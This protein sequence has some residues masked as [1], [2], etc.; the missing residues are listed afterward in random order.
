MEQAARNDAHTERRERLAAR[1]TG[2]RAGNRADLDHIV[3]ELTPL[4][5]HVVRAQGLDP[6]AAEDVVQTTWL[7]LLNH[8]DA[9]RSPSALTAWLV[10]VARREASRV[11]R[12]GRREQLYGFDALESLSHETQEIEDPLLDHRQRAALWRALDDLPPRCRELLRVIARA[13]RPDYDE[14][15]VALGMPRGSIGPTRGRCLAKL[16][17]NLSTSPDWSWP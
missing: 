17:T 1:L 16:R 14:I 11:L 6:A 13:D 4:L 3:A 12:S 8:L 15:A 2:A 9:I 10:T 5:W 7:T